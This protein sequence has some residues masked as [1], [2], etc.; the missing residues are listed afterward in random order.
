MVKLTIIGVSAFCSIT[1]F[2]RFAVTF[3]IH[4]RQSSINAIDPFDHSWIE[5]WASL[6]DSYAVG[7]GAGHAIKKSD[8][9]RLKCPWA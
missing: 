1:T 7:L 6:G 8:N 3:E 2:I 5:E 9:V 4:N